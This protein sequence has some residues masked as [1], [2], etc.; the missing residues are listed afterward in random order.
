MPAGIQA[1]DT[2]RKLADWHHNHGQPQHRD[3]FL[4][5]AADSAFAEGRAD[6]AEALRQRLLRVNP[7]HL[8]KPFSSFGQ[9]LKS[10]DVQ[11]YLSDLRRSYPVRVASDLLASL[12]GNTDNSPQR[13]SKVLPPPHPVLAITTPPHDANPVAIDTLTLY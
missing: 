12:P 10:P 8:L 11:T 2:Y 3:R 1:V 5:L 7:H 9:A 6:E 4:V 13:S